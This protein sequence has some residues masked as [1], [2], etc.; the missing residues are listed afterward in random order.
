MF[1]VI[2][3]DTL[4][5]VPISEDQKHL[6]AH[7]RHGRHDQTDALAIV[8]GIDSNVTLQDG[9][10]DVFQ[11]AAIEGRDHE[12]LRVRHCDGTHLLERRGSTEVL[13]LESEVTM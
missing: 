1:E 12:G 13:H 10:L 11:G 3:P 9:S 4:Q 7:L 2:G 8:V 5:H 6:Q